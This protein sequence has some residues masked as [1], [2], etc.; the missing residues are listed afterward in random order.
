MIIG[1][2]ILAVL[3]ICFPYQINEKGGKRKVRNDNG[4]FSSHYMATDNATSFHVCYSRIN[5]IPLISL[6]V[7]GLLGLP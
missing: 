2:S 4:G 7:T 1:C 5:P 3:L 6:P